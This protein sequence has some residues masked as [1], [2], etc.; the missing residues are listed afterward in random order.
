MI[1]FNAGYAFAADTITIK[2]PLG[3]SSANIT[4]GSTI[5]LSTQT[6]SKSNLTFGTNTSFGASLST[7][8][9]EGMTVTASSRFNPTTAVIKSEIGV[10][11]TL[12]KTTA[13]I[14]NLSAG[15]G[16]GTGETTIGGTTITANRAAL[17]SGNAILEGLSSG[18]DIVLDPS[19]SGFQ[20]E[21]MPNVIGDAC[22]IGTS[23][24]CQYTFK[25][26]EKVVEGKDFIGT[27]PYD[28]QQ[29]SSGNATASVNTNTTVDIGSSQFS[30]VFAQSF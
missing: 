1:I 4:S 13:N 9:S 14:S 17:A 24:A 6:G 27:K 28:G 19:K 29:F 23:D 21:A 2:S 20:V 26:G 7:Q 10:G 18:I 12:G 16:E 5:N 15:G 11:E 30:S 22:S 8:F 3:E 25:S